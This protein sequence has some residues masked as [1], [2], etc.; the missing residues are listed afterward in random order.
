MP[1]R[2]LFAPAQ[3]QAD[4]QMLLKDPAFE[5][6]RSVLR[7]LQQWLGAEAVQSNSKKGSAVRRRKGQR[8]AADESEVK[9]QE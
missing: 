6:H 7:N 2:G 1:A 5:R 8:P 4:V 3:L 9:N